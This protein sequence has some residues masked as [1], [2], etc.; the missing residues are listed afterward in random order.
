M[1]FAVRGSGVMRYE[2]Q[3]STFQKCGNK[4]DSYRSI[5]FS[6]VLVPVLVIYCSG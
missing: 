6:S 4:L 1:S 5:P 3:L 2:M